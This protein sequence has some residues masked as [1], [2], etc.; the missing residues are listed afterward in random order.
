MGAESATVTV[1]AS[2]ASVQTGSAEI[3]STVSGEE[4]EALPLNGRN[5]QGLGSL[6]PG[7]YN[8]SPV[9]GLGT[10]GFNTTNALSV[11]GQ[12][13]GGSLYLLDGVWNTSSTNHNQTNIMPNPDSIAEVK[14]LQN[15]YDSKYTLMGGGVIMVVTKSGGDNFHGGLWEFFRNTALDDR[16]YFSPTVPPEHQN[17]FGWQLG[18]PVFVP[19][20]YSRNNHKTFF[21]YNHQIVRLESQSVINGSGAYGCHA[22]R[23]LSG[24]DQGPERRQLP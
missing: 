24:H 12:G 22:Q 17:I 6:M 8:N 19:R 23:H 18:G 15:N 14:V 11:N 13:L 16:N 4:T 2:A 5:Y 9:A 7:V 3:S 10:G 21:Y 1:M 20:L